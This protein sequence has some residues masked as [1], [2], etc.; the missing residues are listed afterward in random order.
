MVASL[1]VVHRLY[2]AQASVGVAPGLWSTGS[3]VVVYAL[4]GS[5]VRGIFLD[6]GLNPLLLHCQVESS[7]LTHWESPVLN[8]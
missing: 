8:Y 7:P 6:H 2:G 5:V 4:S 1:A 3:L